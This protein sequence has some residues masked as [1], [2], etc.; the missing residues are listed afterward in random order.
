MRVSRKGLNTHMN[1]K[2][3][4]D[5]IATEYFVICYCQWLLSVMV[6]CYCEFL[7]CQ[8]ITDVTP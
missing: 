4:W 3:V 5:L 8:T 1:L 7:C 2:L 6:L